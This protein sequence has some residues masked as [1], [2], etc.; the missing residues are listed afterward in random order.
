MA[1]RPRRSQPEAGGRERLL[2]AAA[3]LFAAKGYAGASVRDILRAAKVTAPVLY[4]HFGSKEGLFLGLVRDGLAAAEAEMAKALA[5]A[6]T[7][8]EKVRAFCRVHVGIQERFADLRWVVEAIV[9]G[10]PKAAPR[11]DF[12]A[13]FA[14]LVEQLADLVRAAVAAGEF[15]RCDPTAAAL[16]ILGAAEIAAR[17]RRRGGVSPAPA[18]LHDDVLDVVLEGLLAEGAASGRGRNPARRKA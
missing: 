18:N 10:P 2:A 7:P 12:R 6:S 11:F 3:K 4:Y 9:S 17:A 13:L 16:A 5:A 14:Q 1:G 8:A 15:R